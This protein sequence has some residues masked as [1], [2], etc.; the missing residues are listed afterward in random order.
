[1]QSAL[2][3]PRFRTIAIAPL[4]VARIYVNPTAFRRLTQTLHRLGVLRG[5]ACVTLRSSQRLY[6]TAA[7]K[8]D[9]LNFR[10]FL[11]HR[12]GVFGP[13]DDQTVVLDGD[14]APIDAELIE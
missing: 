12:L 3:P 6:V 8:G 13:P 7:D 9:N 2:P 4:R 5:S 1:M 11:N 14:R 10:S